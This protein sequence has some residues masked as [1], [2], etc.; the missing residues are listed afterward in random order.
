MPHSHNSGSIDRVTYRLFVAVDLPD[1]AKEQVVSICNGINRAKWTSFEQLHL[2]L[3]F[4]GAADE[5]LFASIKQK[6]A[7]VAMTSFKLTL[8]GTGCFPPRRDPRILWVGLDGHEPLIELQNKVERAL[9]E[10][11]IHREERSFSPHITIA[12]LKEGKREEVLAYL[13]KHETFRLPPFPVTEFFLYSS[14]LSRSGAIHKKE[15]T[16]SLVPE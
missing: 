3:K 2:T 11:G 7:T 10:I 16:Y 4:I 1:L 14:T 15:A 9:E 6:L 13:K 8:H 5:A 12:R